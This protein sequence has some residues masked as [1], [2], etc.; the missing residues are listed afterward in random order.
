MIDETSVIGK[1]GRQRFL[2]PCRKWFGVTT[3]KLYT[4]ELTGVYSLVSMLS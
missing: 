2:L 1:Y 3:S 4:S